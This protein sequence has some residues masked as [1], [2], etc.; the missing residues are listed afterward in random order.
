MSSQGSVTGWIGRL[1]AGDHQAA[2]PLW[3]RYFDRLVRLARKQL[4]VTPRRVA[5]EEDVVLSAFHSFCQG[6]EHGQFP[7]LHDRDDLWQLLVVI[8]ARKAI[9]QVHHE[10]RKK[11]GEGKVG[12]ESA[13]PRR[14]DASKDDAAL[15]Q[16]VGREPTPEFAALVADQCRHLLVSLGDD[17]LRSV[18]VWKMEG[19][20]NDE[21]ANKLGCV[22]RTVERKLRAIRTIW[23][24]EFTR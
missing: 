9:D 4:G 24:K 19:Y 16:L 7:R 15:D 8:T 17:S 5:D 23:S 6:A 12:G 18:A 20:S 22:A 10:K 13:V 11:R 21:I 1:K 3:E 2:Q 14:P